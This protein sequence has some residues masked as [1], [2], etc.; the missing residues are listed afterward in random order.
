MSLDKTPKIIL[1]VSLIAFIMIGIIPGTAFASCILIEDNYLESVQESKYAF[2]GTVTKIENN[3]GPQMVH[4]DVILWVGN[5]AMNSTYILENNNMIKNGDGSLL[6]TSVDVG[7]EIGK[8]YVVHVFDGDS[9]FQSICSSGLVTEQRF[10]D[11]WSVVDRSSPE[12]YSIEV[13]IALLIAL[14]S[15]IISVLIVVGYWVKDKR[16]TQKNY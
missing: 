6:L 4:F 1:S 14:F 12:T 3:I 7:Y 10:W 11:V 5:N 9:L 13:T 8:T 15:A 2:K 16:K